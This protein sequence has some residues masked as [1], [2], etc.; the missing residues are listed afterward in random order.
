MRSLTAGLS[1]GLLVA[2]T[3]PTLAQ[4]ANGNRANNM[5]GMFEPPPADWLIVQNS[6]SM[7]FDGTT[8]TLENVTPQTIMFADR[9]QRMAGDIATRRFIDDWSSGA[10]SFEAD[11][12]NASLSV[13]VGNKEQ[14]S[15]VELTNP[16]LSGTSLS[17]DVTLLEGELPESGTSTTLFIDWWYGPRGGV[18][19]YGPYGG[20]RCAWPW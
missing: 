10:N 19:H 1:L 2:V 5:A 12:P 4:N 9:P 18:C 11:P 13:L 20:T 8:L 7:T 17:Y 3:S 15:I 16:Q 6:A 14:I